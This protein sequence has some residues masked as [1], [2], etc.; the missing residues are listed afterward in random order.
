MGL[1]RGKLVELPKLGHAII[2]TDI[3]GNLTDYN[4][5][6]DIWKKYGDKNFHFI[7]TGDFIHAMGKKDDKSVDILESVE[8]HYENCKNFHALLG[9]H[10][11]SAISMVSV[12]KGGV[13]QSNSFITLLKERFKDNWKLK[14]EEY[15]NFF[16]KLPVAVKTANKL[17]ISH[18]G[19]PRDVKSIDDIVH[20][21]DDGYSEANQNL[22]QILWNRE[23]NFNREDLNK[24]LDVV[25]C[26]AMIVGHTPVDGSKMVYDNQLIVSSSFSLGK[27]SY[28]VIDLKKEIRNARELLKM[29]KNLHWYS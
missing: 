13:N 1:Y 14:L 22:Y 16:K 2:V 6:L 25:D 23:E 17:F 18:G 8:Y 29:E 19:P 12:Y 26:N 4:K 10:E 28:L 27:K 15:Q 7:L 11:W 9:N 21:A 5:Y 3:H 24:F 20:I